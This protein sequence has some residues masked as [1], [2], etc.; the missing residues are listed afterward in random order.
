M[1]VGLNAVSGIREQ[2]SDVD[3]CQAGA[4]HVSAFAAYCTVT[5]RPTESAGSELK[6]KFAP[7]NV[8][9]RAERGRDFAPQLDLQTA[10][11]SVREYV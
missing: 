3:D 2:R 9:V 1:T 10:L 11:G 5:A 8:S 6:P 4:P 7:S